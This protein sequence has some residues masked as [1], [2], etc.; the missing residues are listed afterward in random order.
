MTPFDAEQRTGVLWTQP[1]GRA[2]VELP[3]ENVGTVS[4]WLYSAGGWCLVG[5]VQLTA[6]NRT[7]LSSRGLKL[8]TRFEA[9]R[10]SVRVVTQDEVGDEVVPVSGAL[11]TV[12]AGAYGSPSWDADTVASGVDGV[13]RLGP[14][15]GYREA[16]CVDITAPGHLPI[17]YRLPFADSNASPRAPFDLLLPRGRE[18]RGTVRRADGG[19]LSPEMVVSSEVLGLSPGLRTYQRLGADG[20]FKCWDAPGWGVLFTVEDGGLPVASVDWAGGE[21]DLVI[22]IE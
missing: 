14:L 16:W 6:I 11:V 1:D 8:P 21:S 9:F 13:V 2:L 17:R 12:V 7:E 5:H 15:V 20:T 18:R 19:T 10:T 22:T 3:P 4:T